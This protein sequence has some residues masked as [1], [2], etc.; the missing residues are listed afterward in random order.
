[1]LQ[2]LIEHQALLE[3]GDSLL[4]NEVEMGWSLRQNE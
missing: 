2:I 3:V 4:L 1:M